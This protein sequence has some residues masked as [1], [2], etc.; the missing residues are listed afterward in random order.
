MEKKTDFFD[1][2]YDDE[3]DDEYEDEWEDENRKRRRIL[4]AIA[5]VLAAILLVFIFIFFKRL[6]SNKNAGDTA[7]VEP[8]AE[9]TAA[10]AAETTPAA[11]ATPTAVS[12]AETKKET[13]APV[14]NKVA[15]VTGV[16]ATSNSA[17]MTVTWNPAEGASSY[18][19]GVNSNGKFTSYETTGNSVQVPTN[20]ISD[21]TV[22]ITVIAKDSAGNESEQYNTSYAYKFEQDPLATP[23]GFSSSIDGDQITITWNA[24]PNA[25]YY[26]IMTGYGAD[27]VWE[28]KYVLDMSAANSADFMVTVYAYP[29]EDDYRYHGSEGATYNISYSAPK[30]LAPTDLAAVMA[31]NDLT[32]TWNDMKGESG[33]TVSVSGPDGVIAS[34][35]TEAYGTSATFTGI[36]EKMSSGNSYTITVIANAGSNTSA[37]DP[38]SITINY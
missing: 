29:S 18:I 33:Y 27:T 19:V 11:S 9:V 37:S 4:I 14:T 6:T 31:G 1:D 3:L 36:G 34:L 38:V 25:A 17:Y 13:A 32:V 10:A 12:T 8:T 28:P 7:A 16:K 35:Q 24:V 5:A 22:N 20:V 21:G 23:T 26:S 15:S 2:D 30:L